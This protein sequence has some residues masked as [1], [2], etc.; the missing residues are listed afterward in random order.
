MSGGSSQSPIELRVILPVVGKSASPLSVMMIGI[1]MGIAG[2]S[3]DQQGGPHQWLLQC[4]IEVGQGTLAR[5]ICHPR[6][7]ENKS[8]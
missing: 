5:V 7:S 6:I 3:S 2:V 4:R 8:A 1:F